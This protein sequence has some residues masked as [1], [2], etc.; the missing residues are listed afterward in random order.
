MYPLDTMERL[1]SSSRSSDRQT[2][3]ALAVA[4]AIALALALAHCIALRCAA[5]VEGRYIYISRS[6]DEG[7]GCDD[8]DECGG[9]DD[10]AAAAARWWR[11]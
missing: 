6:R 2:F 7:C 10:A 9:D 11:W 8:D 1:D 5:F 3:I 4:I